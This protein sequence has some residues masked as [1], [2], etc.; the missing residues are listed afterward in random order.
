MIIVDGPRRQR[1]RKAGF[2]FSG[3]GADS[4][5]T[6]A[7]LH[8]RDVAFPVFS[9][10]ADDVSVT[11]TRCGGLQGVTQLAA[12]QWGYGWDI[13]HNAILACARTVAAASASLIGDDAAAP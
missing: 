9:R 6:I 10:G 7:D 2:L 3:D 1:V 11:A 13:T 4:G 12:G 5:A 8:F